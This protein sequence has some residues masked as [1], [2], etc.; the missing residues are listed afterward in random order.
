MWA[1]S[2]QWDLVREW[3]PWDRIIGNKNSF[4]IIVNV[5]MVGEDRGAESRKPFDVCG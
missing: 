4:T 1:V 5:V 2:T 3:W